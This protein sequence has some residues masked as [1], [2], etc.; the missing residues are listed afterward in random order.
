MKPQDTEYH[1]NGISSD[2][3]RTLQPGMLVQLRWNGHDPV[4]QYL[5]GDWLPVEAPFTGKRLPVRE[6]DRILPVRL[7]QIIAFKEGSEER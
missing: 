7:S 4:P 5:T 1:P 6:C 2:E 3:A